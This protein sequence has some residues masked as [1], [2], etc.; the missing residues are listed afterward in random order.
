MIAV[1]DHPSNFRHPQPVRLHPD[2]PYFAIAPMVEG[3][4][5]VSREKPFE[6]RYGIIVAS[7]TLPA[8]RLDSL[9]RAFAANP[10]LKRPNRDFLGDPSGESR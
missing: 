7:E 6:A 5:E 10:T 3:E 4:F 1:L 8:E 9:Q 2:M